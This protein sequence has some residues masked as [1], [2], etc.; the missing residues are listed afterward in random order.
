MKCNS[1]PEPGNILVLTLR[2]DRED[3]VRKWTRPRLSRVVSYAQCNRRRA[4]SFVRSGEEGGIAHSF[5]REGTPPAVDERGHCIGVR[6]AACEMNN[7]ME[8]ATTTPKR[9]GYILRR[10]AQGN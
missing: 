8:H 5:V 2:P 10:F 3:L 6:T 4:L 9:R 7:L 1:D